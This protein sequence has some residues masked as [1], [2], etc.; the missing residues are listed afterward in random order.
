MSKTVVFA[1]LFLLG[2]SDAGQ[3][4]MEA[5]N[6]VDPTPTL[7]RSLSHFDVP[8]AVSVKGSDLYEVSSSVLMAE[9]WV[10]TNVLNYFPSTKITTIVV[11]TDVLCSRDHEEKWDL[12]LPSL[13]NIHHSLVRWGLEKEIKMSASFSDD[14]LNPYSNS[15]R[16]DL[17]VKVIS[18]LLGF[19]RN[20]NSIYCAKPSLD[21]SPSS[22]EAINLVSAHYESIKKLGLFGTF[23]VTGIN[24]VLCTQKKQKPKSRKLSFMSSNVVEP[25][26]A[27]PTP[28]PPIRS[29]IGLSIPANVAKSPLSPFRGIAPPSSFSHTKASPPSLSFSFPPEG[30]PVVIPSNPPDALTL[31]PCG[32][33]DMGAPAPETGE[34]RGLWCVAKPSVP[35]DTLQEA[36][37]YACGEGG[38]DCEEIKPHGS[39]YSPDTIIAHASYAFNSY[40]QKNKRNGGTCSFGGTAMIINADPSFL[41]CRFILS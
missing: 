33:M 31:P 15:F 39:C 10:R 26:P 40:W 1:L 5:L 18:P 35:A 9:N 19:F 34:E 23:Q 24:V 37:N 29:S 25:Y 17:A 27:R 8:V 22:S 28:L 6:I 11:G 12:V 13:K 36:I 30:S 38:A 14:C 2:F 3:E 4:S 16:D 21:F 7:L 41:Q 32:A 20:S